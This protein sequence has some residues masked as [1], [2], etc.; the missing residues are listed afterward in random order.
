ML[1]FAVF[2]LRYIMAYKKKEINDLNLELYF[3]PGI[4]SE[5][6]I[7]EKVKSA[8]K[9]NMLFFGNTLENR[10]E[11]HILYEREEMDRVLSM[12][13]EPWVVGATPKGILYVFSPKR[14][15]SVSNHIHPASSFG[16]LI[17]H[18]LTHIFVRNICRFSQPIWLHEGVPGYV[19]RQYEKRNPKRVDSFNVL[20]KRDDWNKSPNYVQA[21]NFT[22]YLIDAFGKEKFIQ[23]LCVLAQ[24]REAQEDFQ[25][26]SDLFMHYFN[27]NFEEIVEQWKIKMLPQ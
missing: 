16:P 13:T 14:L 27:R 11:V 25:K 21:A 3:D 22:S 12:K 2:I 5:G 19:A 8:Y 7:V 9:A 20:H 24:N 10:I 26:F 1:P 17:A 4:D 23:F 18:E 15:E 6:E